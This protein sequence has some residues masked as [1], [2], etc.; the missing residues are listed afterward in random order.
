M[1]RGRPKGSKNKPKTSTSVV[2]EEIKLIQNKS[3]KPR[4]RKV[5]A[6]ISEFQSLETTEQQQS[7]EVEEINPFQVSQ[8]VCECSFEPMAE[9]SLIVS[10]KD[11][12]T[13]FGAYS[14]CRLPIKTNRAVYPVVGYIK[15]DLAKY[16]T[17]GYSDKQI[18]HGC[19]NYL[20]NNQSKNKLKRL[21][22]LYPYSFSIKNDRI[23]AMFLT[24]ERKSKMFWGEGG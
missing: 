6:K 24:T 21:G 22:E 18:F 9:W 12:T 2:K 1:P 7:F 19:I 5:K 20:S 4:G 14:T 8:E 15:A 16:R 10:P 3:S 13:K 23:S 11:E 17:M